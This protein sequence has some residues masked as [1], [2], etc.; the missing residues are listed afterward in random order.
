MNS[1]KEAVVQD[2]ATLAARIIDMCSYPN[3]L[4][5]DQSN[6][7]FPA[8]DTVFWSVGFHLEDSKQESA[9]ASGASPPNSPWRQQWHTSLAQMGR[10][11][12]LHSDLRLDFQSGFAYSSD[13]NV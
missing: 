7:L 12:Q 4:H 8:M 5:Q 1:C 6:V 9:Q 2:S 3:C 10:S 11:R 13:L